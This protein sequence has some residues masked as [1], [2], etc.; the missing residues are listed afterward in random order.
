VIVVAVHAEQGTIA[1]T[2]EIEIGSIDI[3]DIMMTGGRTA[4]TEAGAITH[5]IEITDG[6][7]LPHGT[8]DTTSAEAANTVIVGQIT[9]THQLIAGEILNVAKTENIPT[10]GTDLQP[11]IWTTQ[12]FLV[13]A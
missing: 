13:N 12:S 8:A 7:D 3:V 11:L 2:T 5:R 1:V 9:P 6:D 4:I 10:A